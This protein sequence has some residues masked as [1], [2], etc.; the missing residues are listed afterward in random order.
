VPCWK[1]LD[2]ALEERAWSA[3]REGLDKGKGKFRW[4]QFESAVRTKFIPWNYIQ[5]VMTRYRAVKQNGRSVAEYIVER[6]RL[7]SSLGKTLTKAVKESSFKEGLN[8]WIRELLVVFS[9]L[10]F[11]QYKTKAEMVDEEAR[12]QRAA[13][14]SSLPASGPD[15]ILDV[16]NGD[17]FD[18]GSQSRESDDE[19]DESDEELE[20]TDAAE[21]KES[22]T[23]NSDGSE[24]EPDGEE[25]EEVS[26]RA[27]GATSVDETSEV[28]SDEESYADA[29]VAAAVMD[30]VHRGWRRC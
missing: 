8:R 2:G 19:D 7:E 27:S 21:S 10:P 30:A 6:E 23:G 16:D 17:G 28:S 25:N 22:D 18:E 26:D 1:G 24:E 4:K 9:D 29:Y 12:E 3:L 13:G 20:D 14:L 11:E 5:Q 15:S